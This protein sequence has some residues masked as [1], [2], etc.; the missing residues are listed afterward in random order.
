VGETVI[1]TATVVEGE[2]ITPTGSVDFYDDEILLGAGTLISSGEATF[3][4]STL[5][6]GTHVITATYTGDDNFGASTGT[7]SPNQ[8]VNKFSTT[9]TLVS[10]PNPSVF[11]HAVTFTATVTSTIGT[12]TGSVDFYDDEI[13][14]GNGLLNS[15]GEAT[16]TTS[17]L[18]VGTHVITATY[19]GDGNYAVSTGRLSSDQVV[20]IFKVYLPLVIR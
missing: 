3:S 14:L 17:T 18:P 12:P 4:T 15:S 8:Q 20:V 7:L 11:G 10:L 13:L 19:T 16:F 5:P 2:P 1:F 6:A 9:I